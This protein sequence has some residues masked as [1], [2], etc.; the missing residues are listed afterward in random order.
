MNFPNLLTI[1]RAQHLCACVCW[2]ESNLLFESDLF[3][4]VKSSKCACD[5]YMCMCMWPRNI[6]LCFLFWPKNIVYYILEGWV[7]IQ[8]KCL[9]FM[10]LLI[11]MFN[12]DIHM[13]G[14]VSDLWIFNFEK[15]NFVGASDKLFH[16]TCTG[17]S[18]RTCGLLG[19]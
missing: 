15:L 8:S 5:I 17:V 19:I 14:D 18:G 11:D 6:L 3:I 16:Q 10:T 4:P 12:C 2:Y 7:N 13:N 1:F 9:N